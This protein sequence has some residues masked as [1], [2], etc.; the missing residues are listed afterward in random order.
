MELGQKNLQECL[1][2]QNEKLE[3]ENKKTIHIILSHY[4]SAFANKNFEKIMKEVEL[5]KEELAI[6]YKNI[7]TFNPVPGAGF[8]KNKDSVEYIIPDFSIQNKDGE[9]DVRLNKTRKRSINISAYYQNLLTETKDEK[10][11]R[12]FKRKN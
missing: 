4:Y 7:E 5:N 3:Y 9:I 12:F 1:I 8:S 11:Q 6:V 2:I 10:N